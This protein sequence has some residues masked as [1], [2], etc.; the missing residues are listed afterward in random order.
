MTAPTMTR[1]RQQI[2]HLKSFVT[3]EESWAQ[4]Q[5]QSPTRDEIF[6]TVTFWRYIWQLVEL[7]IGDYE[8]WRN[9]HDARDQRRR[10]WSTV[11]N[12]AQRQLT[13]K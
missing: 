5:P 12:V 13:T 4:T 9:D 8:S 11:L 10:F 7:I 6:R 3:V 1:I 2:R